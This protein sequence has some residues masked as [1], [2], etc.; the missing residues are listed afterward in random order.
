MAEEETKDDPMDIVDPYE[1]ED[2]VEETPVEDAPEEE[3]EEQWSEQDRALLESSEIDLDAFGSIQDKELAQSIIKAVGQT[4]QTSEPEPQPETESSFEIDLNENFFDPD[5]VNQFKTMKSHY[6]AQ[7]AELRN[8]LQSMN[9]DSE[10]S[11][12]FSM[13]DELDKPSIF[14]VGAV[15]PSSKEGRNRQKVIDE[16]DA[17]KAGYAAKNRSI[18]ADD[19]LLPKAINLVF[20]EQLAETVRQDFS[21]K[22]ES[23]HN[24]RIA[25]PNTRVSKPNNKVAEATRNVAALMR[26][27]GMGNATDTFD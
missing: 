14:G 16:M 23:R 19:Q 8:Q 25:R 12:A 26:D 21:D 18:P 5:V 11:K 15:K 6:D 2:V 24:S 17:L 22:V 4:H 10:S 1:T 3:P 13:F 7:I 27:R 9:K 20:G